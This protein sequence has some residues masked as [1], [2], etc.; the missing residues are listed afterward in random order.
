MT[1]Q[2]LVAFN[3]ARAAQ[4]ERNE[5]RRIRTKVNDARGNPGDAGVRWPFELLQNALDAGP[6]DGRSYVNVTFR[7][8]P[9]GL[10]FEHD[11]AFFELQD[12]AAL[13]S[14]GSN[15]EFETTETT[16]RFGTGFLV[17]HVLSTRVRVAG[18]LTTEDQ[19]EQFALNLDRTGD[20]GEIAANMT[21]CRDEIEQAARIENTDTTHSAQF[22]YLSAD[23][24]PCE[25][26]LSMLSA[27][28]PYLFATCSSLGSATIT[29][30]AGTD[31]WTADPQEAT[32]STL[33]GFTVH[34]RRVRVMERDLD[35]RVIRADGATGVGAVV[36]LKRTD[37][38]WHVLLPE[39]SFPR[40]FCRYPVRTSGFLP[41]NFVLDAPFEL[42]QERRALLLGKS[43]V[44]QMFTAALNAVVP[45]IDLGWNEAWGQR[46][47]LARVAA[48]GTAFGDDES[49]LEWINDELKRLAAQLASL[50]LVETPH[51]FGAAV[52][53]DDEWFADFI[54][55]RLSRKSTAD[56]TTV[57]R[58]WDLVAETQNL[59]PPVREVAVDWSLIGLG[60]SELGLDV[61]LVTLEDLATAVREDATGVDDLVVR[62]DAREWLARFIDC[63]GE[64]GIARGGG[65]DAVLDGLLPDQNGKL[66]STSA[67][68]WAR[69]IPVE[70]KD[71]ASAVGVD[72]RAL[73]LDELLIDELS[74]P[75]FTYG[76]ATLRQVV[77][78][79]L[80]VDDA[81]RKCLDQ[82][83]SVMPESH[84]IAPEHAAVSGSIR[85]VDYI[86]R[87]RGKDGADIAREIPLLTRDHR[88]V[89]IVPTQRLLSPVLAWAPAAR[90][91]VSIYAN[92]RVLADVYCGDALDVPPVVEALADWGFVYPGPLVNQIIGGSDIKRDR[93]RH[94]VTDTTIDLDGLTI[95]SGEF[96]QVAL[97]HEVFE[98]CRDN[99]DVAADLLGLVLTYVA[100]NDPNWESTRLFDAH[101]GNDAAQ[102][103]VRPALWLA[104]LLGKAWV[105][106]GMDETPR[107][108]V[109]DPD[110]IRSLLKPEWYADNEPAVRLLGQVFGL[111]VLDLRLAGM[112]PELREEI[113]ESL[114]EMVKVLGEDPSKYRDLFEELKARAKVEEQRDRWRRLGRAV[115]DAVK[116]CLENLGLN[117]AVVDRGFD[118]H[119]AYRTFD[120]GGVELVLGDRLLE[121][122][123]TTANSV[124]MTPLQ[125]STAARTPDYALLVVDLRGLPEHRLDEPW[126]NDDIIQLSHIV[127]DVSAKVANTWHLIEEAREE[128]VRISG[129]N[130][131]RYEV[132]GAVWTLG[133]AIPVWIGRAFVRS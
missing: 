122:K 130:A 12:L 6:R 111:G 44:K 14:G 104:D 110:A 53:T 3:N 116:A 66:T 19:R 99:R 68:S 8:A 119:V 13:L 105:P 60:W 47:H 45:L 112:S 58:M 100:P 51:G 21:V 35:Y 61:N 89:H 78:G 127:D 113:E 84:T 17:T 29:T 73:L 32:V 64:C 54:R 62:S 38:G 56:E 57:E 80:G 7:A 82:L 93:L 85:L 133:V 129:E 25:L 48:A 108:V 77:H 10:V 52:S 121:V 86:A 109:P 103:P 39:T 63:V 70:L 40:I 67:L 88:A 94:L 11:A 18:L 81:I 101:R 22:T 4:L 43:E 72:I 126:T 125:A 2:A 106:V 37:G 87:S 30:A 1:R 123:A 117:V 92:S 41:I 20:E 114:A 124:R 55:P 74:N 91:F 9:S 16:G 95:A 98:R 31:T 33:G 42:D 50:K 34:E 5:A 69:D 26:G 115:E 97:L 75:Q 76:L 27:S 59:Y 15:K 120:E 79:D 23:V 28:L 102:V 46:H 65:E 128:V 132:P 71:I 83:K 49:H 131:L 24:S 118:F 96:S 107:L 36:V 90:A